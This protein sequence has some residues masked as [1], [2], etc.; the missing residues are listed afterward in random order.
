MYGKWREPERW[1]EPEDEDEDPKKALEED[2]R[3]LAKNWYWYVLAFLMS[4]VAAAV[5][6]AVLLS[7][8]SLA[9]GGHW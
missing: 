6:V 1:E 8:L 9:L 2:F 4:L 5:Y 3:F 7:V